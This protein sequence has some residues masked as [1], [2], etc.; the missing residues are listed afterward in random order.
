MDDI[1][2]SESYDMKMLPVEQK[3]LTYAHTTHNGH[4]LTVKEERF[5]NSYMK[6]G[7]ATQAYREAGYTGK[8][9]SSILNKPHIL[10]E[11]NYRTQLAAS[12]GVA[13][14]NEIMKY[15]TSV[16]RGEI[17]DQ[18]GLD[19]PLSERTSAAR[20]LKKHYDM[21]SKEDAKKNAEITVFLDW[22][23]PD[24]KTD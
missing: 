22:E 15:L 12:E 17:A 8:S 23:R 11:I 13:D 1:V 19:A 3:P 4:R 6:C 21:A 7:I 5:I 24:L 14:A 2:K 16:M 9:P 20:E 10:D 18:F